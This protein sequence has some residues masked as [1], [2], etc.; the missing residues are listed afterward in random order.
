MNC[1]NCQ[2][3]CGET[4]RYCFRCGAALRPTGSPKKGTHLVP[5]S[6]LTFLSLLGII[7]FFLIPMTEPVSDT[8]W[9]SIENG[10]LSFDP[11]LYSGS[12]ELTVP[13]IVNGQTVTQIGTNCFKD[14]TTLTTVI[15][16]ESVRSIGVG[17]FSGCSSMRGI[18]IPESVTEIQGS[19]FARCSRLEAISLPSTLT[20]LGKGAFNGCDKLNYI[21]Y[22]GLF[23]DWRNLY[24]DHIN[25]HTHVYCTDGTYLHK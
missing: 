24:N 12:S 15:L 14:C 25:I 19:A 21:L 11:Y 4:D 10:V 17:A 5:L 8:P 1:P 18:F 23:E 13:E 3:V 16:P 20:F 6:I 2:N 7:L 22:D 9:F